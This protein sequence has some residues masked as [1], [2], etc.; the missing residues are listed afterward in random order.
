M[1]FILVHEYLQSSRQ[2]L[3]N[4]D[5]KKGSNVP[6]F[7]IDNESRVLLLP[8]YVRPGYFVTTEIHIVT[9]TTGFFEY[10]STFSNNFVLTQNIAI[11][12]FGHTYCKIG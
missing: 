8:T 10:A 3:S 2:E 6:N 4:Y 5:V 7:N 11:F 12:I 1:N 9:K